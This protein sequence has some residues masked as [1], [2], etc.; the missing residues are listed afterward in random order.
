MKTNEFKNYHPIVNFVYF[1]SV[2]GF[3]MVFMHPICLG[4]SLV[5]SLVCAIFFGGRKVLKRNLTYLLPMILIA[6]IINPL[7]NHEGV[8][9]I[10]YLPDSNPLT[11]ESLIY[12]VGAATMLASVILWFFCC[13]EIMTSDKFIY[14]FG[15][16]IP[17]LSLIFSMT[18][19]FV[20]KF[21]AQFK[22]VSDARKCLGRDASRGGIIEKAKN[23][24]T[25]LS[26]MVTWSLENALDTADSMKSRGYGLKGRTAFSIFTFGKRD[27]IA[28]LYLLLADGAVLY[29][30]IAGKMYFRYFPSI[31]SA[32][33]SPAGVIC[34]AAYAGLCVCP[35][36]I[37]LWE[38]RKWNSIK[39]KT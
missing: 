14:L 15:R 3:S 8:T 26:A 23:G 9:V 18:L 35:L 36:A 25:L 16:V 5:C 39:S 34:F 19:R 17:S 29:G 1:V 38:V 21:T 33:L 11:L 2:I 7:F 28:L 10:T 32:T 22:T 30:G 4:I 24:L 37:E 6:A 13:N 27:K 31:K 20:P 12:G